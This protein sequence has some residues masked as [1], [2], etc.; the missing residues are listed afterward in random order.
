MQIFASPRR[1]L[2]IYIAQK[3]T[4]KSVGFFCCARCIPERNVTGFFCFSMP[5]SLLEKIF[6]K[7]WFN[8]LPLLCC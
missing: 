1:S 2:Y 6:L 4:E 3:P 8:F 5:V 7:M